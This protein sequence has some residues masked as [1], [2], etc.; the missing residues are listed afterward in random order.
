MRAVDCCRWRHAWGS[1]LAATTRAFSS[2]LRRFPERRRRLDVAISRVLGMSSP[3]TQRKNLKRLADIAK[4][5][6]TG[7]NAWETTDW[8]GAG[9]LTPTEQSLIEMLGMDEPHLIPTTPSMRV[10]ARL[11][12]STVD[13][14]NKLSAGKMTARALHRSGRGLS[15]RRSGVA[16]PRTRHLH[17][18]TTP[19]AA[20]APSPDLVPALRR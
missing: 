19:T 1:Q 2:F 5:V 18:G 6:G 11:T 8:A 14:E 10:V 13:T 9:K 12:D 17:I 7:K 3:G 15:R 20:P 16:R 4:A